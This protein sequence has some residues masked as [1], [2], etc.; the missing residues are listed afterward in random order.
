MVEQC[1]ESLPSDRHPLVSVT[2]PAYNAER[3]IAQTLASV[4]AQTYQ[5]FEVLVVDDGSKD[6]TAAIVRKYL[7][8]DGRIHLLQQPNSGV[9]AARNLGIERSHGE[10]IACL[11]ADDIWY[12]HHL[13]KQVERF[14]ASSASVGL[15]YSWSVDIDEQDNPTGGIRAAEIE[16]NTYTTLICHNFLGNASASMVRRC[17]FQQCGGYDTSLRACHSQGCEDW[18]LYLRIAEQFEFRAVPTFSVGYRKLSGS[19]SGDYGQ[20]SRSHGLVMQSVRERH[21]ELPKFLFRL[22][23]SNLYFYFAHQSQWRHNQLKALLWLRRAILAD[24]LTCWIR[25]G[26]YQLLIHGVWELRLSKTRLSDSPTSPPF[27]LE[28]ITGRNRKIARQLAVGNGFHWVISGLSHHRLGP[29]RPL[30]C[31]SGRH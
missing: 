20:M 29:S 3:F 11:D 14:S 1:L 28:A 21:P 19:M 10:F 24:P 4:L 2:I 8:R 31:N 7:E 16:G 30:W 13:I 23:A 25:P 22:S 15:V 18:D 6:D 12:P 17:S 27:C 26:L 9:A 5:R